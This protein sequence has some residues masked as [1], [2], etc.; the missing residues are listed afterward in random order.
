MDMAHKIWRHC[1][2]SSSSCYYDLIFFQ[3]N[4]DFQPKRARLSHCEPALRKDC[5]PQVT[6]MA[7]SVLL[8]DCLSLRQRRFPAMACLQVMFTRWVGQVNSYGDRFEG[9][10][11][12]SVGRFEGML[13]CK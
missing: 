10:K 1:C 7:V 12:C 3:L 11:E 6:E 5:D 2:P 13:S 4:S 8:Y 9:R